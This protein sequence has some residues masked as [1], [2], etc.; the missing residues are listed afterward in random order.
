MIVLLLIL[1]V[2]FDITSV[3]KNLH[4][5]FTEEKFAYF[6][7]TTFH[8]LTWKKGFNPYTKEGKLTIYG[9]IL[10]DNLP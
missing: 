7:Q 8:K 3:N 10:A 1:P 6:S 5:E 9:H 2:N 4:T